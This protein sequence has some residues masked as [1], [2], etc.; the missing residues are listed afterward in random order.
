MM[1]TP[2]PNQPAPQILRRIAKR[3]ERR[4]LAAERRKAEA[5]AKAEREEA[6]AEH[7]APRVQRLPVYGRDGQ[8]L[9]GPRVEQ[10]GAT[11]VRSNPVKQLAARSR[12]KDYP[13]ISK[14]HVIAAERLLTAWEEAHGA[15]V[16]IANYGER[17]ASSSTPGVISEASLHAAHIHIAARDEILRVQARLG[18][19]WPV[20]HAVVICHIVPTAWG[21]AQGM[22]SNVAIGYVAAA[23]DLLV[24]CFEPPQR[25]QPGRILVA[26]FESI[27]FQN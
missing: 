13:T 1:P 11:M 15:P 27:N 6:K 17:M 5:K 4:Q 10:S 3:Q 8:M 7:L 24:Q 9:R 2:T 23:L 12:G 26:E 19:L 16:L 21:E 22:Q 20:I 18:A 14:A 25:R